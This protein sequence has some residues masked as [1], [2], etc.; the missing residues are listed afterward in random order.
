MESPSR[1]YRPSTDE[2][3][4]EAMS[5]G[6]GSPLSLPALPHNKIATPL[7]RPEGVQGQLTLFDRQ[8]D[9]Q[10]VGNQQFMGAQL[11]RGTQM[12]G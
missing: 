6:S 2:M 10:E 5:A 7:S 9:R 8:V 1:S 11:M 12:D 3:N 4:S